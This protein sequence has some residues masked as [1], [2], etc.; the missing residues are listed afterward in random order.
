MFQRILLAVD[1]GEAGTVA[2]SFTVA[3]AKVCGAAV[4]VVHVNRY[5]FGMPGARGSTAES[6]AE[7]AEVVADSLRDI[8]AAGVSAAGFTYRT[9]AR[10]I[11][12]AICELAAQC[13]ADVIVV[14]SRRRRFGSFLRRGVREQIARRTALPVIT[15]PAPL[16]VDEH[17][18][19]AG[20]LPSPRDLG[21]L[22]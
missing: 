4:Q 10:D 17:E 7:A 16:Q 9:S 20:S 6:P 13:R 1:T 8:H 22:S 11:P 3:L 5:L 21:V 19:T 12:A 15:A 14:G 18:C 2:T